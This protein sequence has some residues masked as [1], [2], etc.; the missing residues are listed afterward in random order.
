MFDTHC[1]LNFSRFKGRVDDVVL[2]AKNAG[3]KTIIVPG[4]DPVSSR[5][6][7]EIANLYDGVYAAVGIHPHHLF[8]AKPGTEWKSELEEI[9]GMLSHPRVLALGEV[10]LDRHVY[11]K[12]KYE[13]YQIDDT[14]L[15]L[16]RDMLIK[17]MHLANWH[18]KAV[19]LHNREA[20][21]DLIEL[22]TQH[23]SLMTSGRTV[24]HC[25]EPDE[26]LLEFAKK[27]NMYIGID[28]DVTYDKAKE[29]FAKEVPLNM[30]VLE[31][32]SPYLL[33][34]PLRSRK[35]FP[36]EPANISVIVQ[37]IAKLK[38]V[39]AEEIV[40]RTTA[41]ASRLFGLFSTRTEGT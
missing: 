4:T 1:H 15:K 7:I 28:G 10:G 29:E 3:I 16:Q 39:E 2:R 11:D 30:L 35:K 21:G 34:E 40:S 26:E 23:T 5:K 18:N 31:T 8:T 17:Q 13:G 19:I 20:K 12:T 38:G 22:L 37:Y 25:C 9:D 14:F 6:A 33:P 36:N 24:L 41:N 27:H 32:D